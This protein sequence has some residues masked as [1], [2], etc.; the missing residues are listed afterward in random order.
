MK[1]H[2]KTTKQFRAVTVLLGVCM[3]LTYGCKQVNNPLE[4]SNEELSI[5]GL[6]INVKYAESYDQTEITYSRIWPKGISTGFDK[7]KSTSGGELMVDYERTHE[8]IAYDEE[9]Y[10]SSVSEFL[11][12]DGE[13]NMP[14]AVYENLKDQMPARSVDHD[15]LVR[16]EMIDGQLNYYSKS[17][18]LMNSYPVNRELYKIDP[19]LLDSLKF[20]NSDTNESVQS[21]IQALE[22][23]GIVF[24]R[25]GDRYIEYEKVASSI[26][27]ADGIA[28]EQYVLNL[29]NGN[30]ILYA[31]YNPSGDLLA[32]NRSNFKE[33]NGISILNNEEQFTFGEINNSWG[34]IQRRTITRENIKIVHN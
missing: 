10:M 32:L 1:T 13:M 17:G 30:I 15:P 33:V 28:K 14:E 9:G 12:G 5:E 24:N 26:N 22:N 21:N 11:E 7:A 6:N 18:K 8:I 3:L 31:T 27:R 20:G 34:I 16:T 4:S 23:A 25:I 29:Q 2:L 19:A